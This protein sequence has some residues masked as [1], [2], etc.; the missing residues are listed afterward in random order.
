MANLSP[1]ALPLLASPPILES[2]FRYLPGVKQQI[3][4]RAL[5]QNRYPIQSLALPRMRVTSAAPVLILAAICVTYVARNAIYNNCGGVRQLTVEKSYEDV[6]ALIRECISSA[7][8]LPGGKSYMHGLDAWVLFELKRYDEALLAQEAANSYLGNERGG[9]AI[10]GL[11][12]LSLYAYK[13]DRVA[14]AIRSAKTA[15]EIALSNGG[16]T[17]PIQYHLGRALR[18][19]SRHVEAIA[20]LSEG[21]A[22]QP[23]Y[24]FAYWERALA[25]EGIGDKLAAKEDLEVVTHLLQSEGHRGEIEEGFLRDV[26][27]KLEKYAIPIRWAPHR[28]PR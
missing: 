26:Q 23:Q 25:Y 19:A 17:M 9:D 15:R 20:A 28:A 24:P 27:D 13:A 8:W 14:L 4:P 21:I 5:R 6:H 16:T 3:C 10:R 11:L 7:Q 18:A 2:S 12:H 22:F 1:D